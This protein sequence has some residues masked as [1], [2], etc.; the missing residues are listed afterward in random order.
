M[1]ECGEI[2]TQCTVNGNKK[3]CNCC[4]KHPGD[5]SES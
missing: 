4:A 3:S 5:P 2:K 1:K